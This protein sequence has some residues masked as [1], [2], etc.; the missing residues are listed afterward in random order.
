MAHDDFERLLGTMRD[1]FHI[2]GPLGPLVRRN[3]VNLES[4]NPADSAF[5]NHR[6]LTPAAGAGGLDD[7]V[8]KGFLL[9]G[10]IAGWAMFDAAGVIV[11]STPFFSADAVVTVEALPVAHVRY[12]IT[13][14]SLALIDGTALASPDDYRIILQKQ[15]VNATTMIVGTLNTS[16]AATA[17]PF[18]VA[19]FT[20]VP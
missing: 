8:P 19:M 3:G 12:T 17:S 9:E 5:V 6:V 1:A 10:R 18:S 7:A 4:R 16:N 11:R 20:R 13:H 2:G 14:S 15:R